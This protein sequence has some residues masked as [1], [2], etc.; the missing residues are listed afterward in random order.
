MLPTLHGDSLPNGDAPLECARDPADQP[1]K[2]R[3]PAEGDGH[4]RP[5]GLRLYGP[6]A[7]ADADRR[8]GESLCLGCPGRGGASH[9]AWETDGGVP[10]RAPALQDAHHVRPVPLQRRDPDH[11]LHAERREP[12]LPTEGQAG[13]GGLEEG[14]VPPAG[15]RSSDAARRVRRVGEEQ[16]QQ[17]VVLRELHPGTR[18]AASAGHP[19]AARADHGQLQDGH[20]ERGPQLSED[21]AR[22]RRGILHQRCEEGPAGRLPHHGG[23]QRGV[24]SSILGALQQVA[25]V[26]PVP[27]GRPHHEGVHAQHHEHRAQVA[28]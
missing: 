1:R 19:E 11:H 5:G 20:S 3:A 15:R 2:C 22:H 8:H 24:H 27:R 10:P 13:P 14:Q 25:R 4:Q 6:A 18:D 26:G 16:L 9:P 17:S 23:R 28:G 21:P 7:D 12:L